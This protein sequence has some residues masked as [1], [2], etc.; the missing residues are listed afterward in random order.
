[1]SLMVCCIY[2]VQEIKDQPLRKLGTTTHT[3]HKTEASGRRAEMVIAVGVRIRMMLMTKYK[4][5]ET[6]LG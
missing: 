6:V 2:Y 4:Q 1:M 5:Q 3:N